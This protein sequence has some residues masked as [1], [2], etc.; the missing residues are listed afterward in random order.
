MDFKVQGM[1][2]N[3]KKPLIGIVSKH[4]IKDYIRPDT[5][6]RDEVK[7]AVFDNGGIAIG[8]L[9]TCPNKKRARNDWNNSLTKGEEQNLIEQIHLCD[10]IILQGGGF[11]DE[12]ECYVANY[13][14]EHDI[15]ILGICAGLN[16]MVRAVG[17]KIER[18]DSEIHN[19]MEGYVHEIIISKESNLYKIINKD[20]VLVN[21]R[22]KCYVTDT[23]ILNQAAFSSDNVI[24]AVEDQNKKFY[25]AVQFH[26][27]SLYMTDKNM[28]AIFEYFMHICE[29]NR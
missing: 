27:E 9:P 1:G 11:S 20:K 16:N 4:F 5:F 24:E 23:S 13:C 28:N 25:L 26:P 15:P 8:I 29:D 18:M 2:E 12:Y 22:H 6:I 3:M 7:Q 21:S 14:Y 19:S 10:G 17:G